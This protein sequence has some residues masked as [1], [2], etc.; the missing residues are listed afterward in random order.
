M[1]IPG[2][3]TGSISTYCK[4]TLDDIA[5]HK[6]MQYANGGKTINQI[7]NWLYGSIIDGGKPTR[8]Y[9]YVSET[10]A[11]WGVILFA[12][13][14]VQVD[15]IKTMRVKFP[16]GADIVDMPMG[17]IATFKKTDW[18]KTFKS[19]PWLIQRA[20]STFGENQHNEFPDGAERFSPIW[21][22][23]DFNLK[24]IISGDAPGEYWAYMDTLEKV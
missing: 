20:T 3:G 18:G 7:M 4:L 17:R 13:Q 1:W 11:H 16:N 9:W 5:K 12:N 19:H 10:E 15:E 24:P 23:I 22:P 21:S 2:L 8:P 6:A 14:L